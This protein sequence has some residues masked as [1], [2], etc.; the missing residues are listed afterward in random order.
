MLAAAAA[1]ALTLAATHAYLTGAT[2]LATALA[3]GAGTRRGTAGVLAAIAA[4]SAL[5]LG[6]AWAGLV[7]TAQLVTVP[8]ALFLLVYLGCL[9]AAVR[10]PTGAVR[11]AA[12]VACAVVRCCW[13]AAGGPP[14]SRPVWRW[15]RG[16]A[17]ARTPRPEFDHAPLRV[18]TTRKPGGP[19]RSTPAPLRMFADNPSPGRDIRA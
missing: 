18:G 1:V 8:T 12:G 9:A 10:L 5:L 16:R 19:N 3:D 17:A 4:T 6:A 11:L 7:T 15:S 13:R 2:A 14:W